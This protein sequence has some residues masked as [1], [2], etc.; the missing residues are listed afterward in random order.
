MSFQ[1]PQRPVR[2]KGQK[3]IVS[4]IVRSAARDETCTLSLP[5]CHGSA[6][7]AHLRYFGW[8]GMAEKPHDFLAVFAC[9]SCHKKMDL[10][11]GECGFEDIL[12]ALGKTLKRQFE[13]GNFVAR[14]E[15]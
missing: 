8:A 12:L 3:P 6:V 9:D 7:L 11:T 13:S 14:G 15:K 10:R 2:Q 5:G 1:V 4:R